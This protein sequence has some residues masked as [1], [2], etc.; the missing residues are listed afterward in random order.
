MWVLACLPIIVLLVLMIGFQWG[1]T[2][3]APVGLAITVLQ[4]SYFTRQI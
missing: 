4:E 2:D 1:A 3:A